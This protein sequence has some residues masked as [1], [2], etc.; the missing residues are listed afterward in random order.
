MA[1]R[2]WW[3]VVASRSDVNRAHTA[4]HVFHHVHVALA[5]INVHFSP[6]FP[7]I[8]PSVFLHV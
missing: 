8:N 7:P 6:L 4:D 3:T 2:S 1:R 5:A